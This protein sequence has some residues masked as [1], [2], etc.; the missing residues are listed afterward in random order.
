MSEVTQPGMARGT[1]LTAAVFALA[2][3]ALLAFAPFASAAPDPVGSG[4]ATVTLNKGF[5][6]SLKNKGVTIQKIAPAKLKGN[7]ATFSVTGGSIDPLTGQGTLNLGGGLKFKAGKKSAPVKGL[8]IETTKSALTGKVAGKKVKIASLKGWTYVRN[9]FG[10]NITVKQVKLT[11]AAA[12]TLNKKLGTTKPKAFTG[13]K[14]L[15]SANAES[16]PATTTVLP[17]GN[18][19]YT[20][21]AATL[22]KLDK[23][24]VKIATIPPTASPGAGLYQFPITGGTVSPAGTAGTVQSGGGLILE[25]EL[26]FPMEAAPPLV[27]KITLGSFYVDLSAK[28]TTVEVVATSNASKELDLGNLG[29]SSIADLQIGSVAADPAA[30]TVAVSAGSTLQPISAKVLNAFS[31]VY[32]GYKVA[33]HEKFEGKSEQEAKEEAGKEVAGTQIA[34]GD[35]LGTFAMTAQTQ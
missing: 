1:K 7:K 8:V 6:K 9:G 14:K 11:G 35:P 24:E 2:L 32:F 15:G 33:I 34:S 4:T 30:R 5:V 23:V 21:N 22:A 25:Q 27:T 29:R 16:Q 13:N 17:G 18:V 3:F 31:E 26:K 10:V 12:S 20:G 19:T 28:T